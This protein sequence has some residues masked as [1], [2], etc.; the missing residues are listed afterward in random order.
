M[1][2]L[3]LPCAGKST[4]YPQMRPKWL[5]TH[6]DG[7]LMLQKAIAAIDLNQFDQVYIIIV[8]QHDREYDASLILR[9]VFPQEKIKIHILDD[10]TSC[11]GETIYLA[12]KNNKIN[13][14]IVIKDSDNYVKADYSK[15]GNY[16]VGLDIT[17]KDIS[18]L[19]AKSFIKINENNIITDII[20][21]KVQ[22]NIISLG[23]YGFESAELFT[24]AYTSLKNEDFIS[25]VGGEIYVSHIIAYLI[26]MGKTFFS[27]YEAQEFEDWGTLEDWIKV[28]QKHSTYF[29]DIDGVITKNTGK[30][31]KINWANNEEVLPDNINTIK[32]LAQKGAQIFLITSR[33]KEYR[34]KLE[35]LL[36]KHKVPYQ[37]I[38]MGCNHAPRVI[39]NDF[40]PT[41]PFPSC[42][43]L[44]IPRNGKLS[45]YMAKSGGQ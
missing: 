37:D 26:G 4:R 35:E 43:A 23:I 17:N 40:A 22:S 41:N 28:Q 32:A 12:L 7:E 11:V 45:D 42:E 9:Q 5:L 36:L 15:R 16:V 13:G 29:I 14:E 25:T 24:G 30:Y 20:E 31:G 33:P 8:K 10:F 27:Y 2:T 1:R 3:L 38:I 18:R 34:K 44:S 6:P 21:K 39:I 19:S